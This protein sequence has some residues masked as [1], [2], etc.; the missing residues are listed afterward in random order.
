MLKATSSFRAAAGQVA[1][2]STEPEPEAEVSTLLEP[3]QLPANALVR[4]GSPR[5]KRSAASG[6]PQA[7][8]ARWPAGDLRKSR[9]AIETENAP[10]VDKVTELFKKMKSEMKDTDDRGIIN[11]RSTPKISWDAFVLILAVFSTLFEPYKIAFYPEVSEMAWYEWVI[12]IAF[13][14]DILLS[15]CTGIDKGYE[16][17]K[18]RK[19]IVHEYVS[20]WFFFD[21][22]ATVQWDLL[23]NAF[24]SLSGSSSSPAWLQF[25]GLIKVLRLGKAPRLIDNIT[26]TWTCD[27]GYIS[28][29]KFFAVVLIVAHILACFF[30]MVPALWFPDCPPA[31][32]TP[33]SDTI[34]H[35]GEVG[36]LL[37]A[38]SHDDCLGVCGVCHPELISDD[39]MTIGVIPDSWRDGYNVEQMEPLDQYIESLYWALTTM[40][41]IGYGDRGPSLKCEIVYTMIAEVLGLSIFALLLNQITVLQDV[42]GAQ[43]ELHNAEKN[44][45]VQFMKHNGLEADLI[46]DVVKFLNFKTKGHSGHALKDSDVERKP[47]MMYFQELSEDLR[48]QVKEKI[49]LPALEKVGFFGHSEA[50]RLER[51]SLHAKFNEIDKDGGGSLDVDE[52]QELMKRLG[53]HATDEEVTE[54]VKDMMDANAKASADRSFDAEATG[55]L[56]VTFSQFQAWWYFKKHGRPKMPKC[57]LV[58][59]QRLAREMSNELKPYSIQELV[60]SKEEGEPYG[61]RLCLVMTGTVVLVKKPPRDYDIV[62]ARQR[63]TFDKKLNNGLLSRTDGRL[64]MVKPGSV[65]EVMRT[66]KVILIDDHKRP[67]MGEDGKIQEEKYRMVNLS[68]VERDRPRYYVGHEKLRLCSSPYGDEEGEPGSAADG[69]EKLGGEVEPNQFVQEVYSHHSNSNGRQ[70]DYVLVETLSAPGTRGSLV[71]LDPNKKQGWLKDTM[72]RE[73]WKKDGEIV[74]G[75]VGK[76]V[77]SKSSSCPCLPLFVPLFPHASL[78]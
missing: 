13:Y 20:T 2:R 74:G 7:E 3:P 70:G 73:D 67:V 46:D 53:I 52:I 64:G 65:N 1:L 5:R 54:M 37:D 63:G 71:K 38:H 44:A 28:T 34:A 27:T 23:I 42:V 49:F 72:P 24:I 21:V 9:R 18:L 66:C 17:E 50:Q 57:P 33:S 40:T 39:N 11:P 26:K 69:G 19:K 48:L 4:A 60:V 12:D 61:D 36:G 45:I 58:F 56:E 32:Y 47:E 35:D 22:I 55:P 76:R 75:E 77:E 10:K 51:I 59:L 29:I 6:A 15:F 43:Q 30:F 16:I 41:T 68:V 78:T 25:T 14:A 8:P 31:E 62:E